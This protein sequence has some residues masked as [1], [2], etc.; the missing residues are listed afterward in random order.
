LPT[1]RRSRV[2]ASP[3]E[4]VWRVVSD[5]HHLPRWW[6]K[7]HHVEEVGGGRWTKVMRTGKGKP[8]RADEVMTVQERP[9]RLGWTQDL[10]ESP[11]ERLLWEAS[12]ELT[13]E[14]REPG[15]EVTIELRQRLR[16]LNRLGGFMF[17]RASRRLLDEALDGLE[18]TC[19]R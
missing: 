6:P 11:F 19:G 10:E 5:P 2:V 1:V 9:R 3:P 12:T 14:P 16:G 17:R 18:R 15:T 8:V 7:V 4:D 13:L